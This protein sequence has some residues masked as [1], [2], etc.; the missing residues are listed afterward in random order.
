MDFEP[1][2]FDAIFSRDVLVYANKEEKIELFEKIHKW[3]K[4]GGRLLVVDFTNLNDP[5]EQSQEFKAYTK[6]RSYNLTSLQQFRIEIRKFDFEIDEF[7]QI[8]LIWSI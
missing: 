2:T 5:F 8:F 1:E 7:G 3:L 6:S 4:P